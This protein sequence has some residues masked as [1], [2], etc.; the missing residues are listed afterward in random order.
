MKKYNLD[1]SLDG[2]YAVITSELGLTDNEVI[3]RYRGLSK[4]EESFRVI[5]SDL[6]GRP[7]YVILENHIEGHFLI[8]YLALVITRI[9]EYKLG[10]R[11]SIAKIQETLKEAT[12][13][14]LKKDI[15]IFEEK[16]EILED[17]EKFYN[18]DSITN[19]STIEILKYIKIK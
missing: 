12:C 13:I 11:H 4:I 18:L 2:Y 5:K 9:L 7:V 1:K 10:N 14:K 16:G 19:K 15:L 8:C 3:E 6:E 17:I